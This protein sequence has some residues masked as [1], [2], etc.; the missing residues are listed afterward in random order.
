MFVYNVGIFNNLVLKFTV[1][2]KETKE[3]IKCT[4]SKIPFKISLSFEYLIKEIKNIAL[5]VK[6]P[7]YVVGTAGGRTT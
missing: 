3:N 2:N 7:M 1:M 5:D 6:H 4:L